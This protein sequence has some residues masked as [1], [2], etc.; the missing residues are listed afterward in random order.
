MSEHETVREG[1][2]EI[3]EAA[4][5]APIL[6]SVEIARLHMRLSEL[7]ALTPG[8][9]IET[10]VAIGERVTVWAGDVEVATG[11]LV[12]VDG[13]VGVRVLALGDGQSA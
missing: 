6:L 10:G 4:G 13:E 12:D 8:E 2:K 7:A 9:V 1:L 11:E 3:V 5:K